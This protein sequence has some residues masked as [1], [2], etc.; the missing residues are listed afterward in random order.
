[1]PH[2]RA[3]AMPRE[4]TL[5][6]STF[7]FVGPYDDN[8]F[9]RGPQLVKPISPSFLS[10]NNH[11]AT[12]SKSLALAA[13]PISE[14]IHTEDFAVLG[15]DDE[16]TEDELPPSPRRR[17]S[18][19]MSISEEDLPPLYDRE[20]LRKEAYEHRAKY[21]QNAQSVRVKNYG[22]TGPFIAHDQ[23]DTELDGP[24][25]A[26]WV[27]E[28]QAYDC[29]DCKRRRLADG[30]NTKAASSKGAEAVQQCHD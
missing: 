14:H 20:A 13:S 18:G 24:S 15:G 8:S 30:S 12:A 9:S 10:V 5:H 7:F 28:G 1:M 16:T 17:H 27:P 11:S 25:M 3:K 2:Q 23:W 26:L 6:E 19:A 4:K 21:H 29:T 22:R